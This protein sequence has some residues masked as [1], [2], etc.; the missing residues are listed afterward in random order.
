MSQPLWLDLETPKKNVK[1]VG[2]FFSCRN[3]L[4]ILTTRNVTGSMLRQQETVP[5]NNTPAND[6]GHHY[7]AYIPVTIPLFPF[8]SHNI[9]K[10]D[11][12]CV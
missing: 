7:M 1:T 9:L 5:N 12:Y 6:R 4:R 8:N 2:N 3:S 10:V 11:I